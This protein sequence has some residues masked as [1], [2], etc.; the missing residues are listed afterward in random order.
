M[1]IE[2]IVSD[3]IENLAKKHGKFG[4]TGVPFPTEEPNEFAYLDFKKWAYK[5]RGY[6]KIN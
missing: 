6:K 3:I 5:N 4:Q 1:K 2:N